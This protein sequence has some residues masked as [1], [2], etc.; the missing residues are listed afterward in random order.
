MSQCWR[1]IHQYNTHNTNFAS[2]ITRRTNFFHNQS[3]SNCMH[4][5]LVWIV[6]QVMA[7]EAAVSLLRPCVSHRCVLH[8]ALLLASDKWHL[9]LEWRGWNYTRPGLR[10]YLG[11]HN[12]WYTNKFVLELKETKSKI[13]NKMKFYEISLHSIVDNKKISV[14]LYLIKRFNIILC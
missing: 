8:A 13:I 7:A 3:N 1:L 11:N 2:S 5:S 14:F 10:G 9:L 4:I 12:Y 6:A